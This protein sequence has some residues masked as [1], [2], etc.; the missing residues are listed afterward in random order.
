MC[1]SGWLLLQLADAVQAGD[2]LNAF[3]DSLMAVP[4]GSCTAWSGARWLKLVWSRAHHDA[5]ARREG[6]LAA[7]RRVTADQLG[8]SRASRRCDSG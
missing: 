7:L 6:L 5:G 1:G 2:R 8:Y 3:T 4:D